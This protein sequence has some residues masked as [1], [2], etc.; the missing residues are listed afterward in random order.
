M[1]EQPRKV[2]LE[3]FCSTRHIPQLPVDSV[4]GDVICA[5][6][7]P[8]YLLVE[9]LDH[10]DP[11]NPAAGILVKMIDRIYQTSA[12]SLVL[13]R[14][15]QVREAE[16]LARTVFESA[17]TVAYIARETPEKRISSFFQRYIEKERAEI[18]RWRNELEGKPRQLELAHLTR[19]KR[20]ESVLNTLEQ[21]ISEFRKYLQL[22]T[23]M[24]NH[25][26][27]VL[28]RLTELGQENRLEN[29]TVYSAM[30]SQAHHD[31]EDILSH[32]LVNSIESNDVMALRLE[33]ETNLFSVFMVLFALRWFV[34]STKATCQ[35]LKFPTVI[36]KALTSEERIERE[37]EVVGESI[38]LGIVP[39]HWASVISR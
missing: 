18:R 38:E 25:W 37:L 17:T 26:P 19:I 35:W 36:A 21:T 39:T 32:F 31:A 13:L 11:T 33:N 9:C 1:N 15:S 7:A 8:Y 16:V 12:G 4:L 28:E 3:H 29:R 30:C 10:L 2:I 20:R 22:P 27:N 14:L 5:T 23:S 6:S 34:R 24:S